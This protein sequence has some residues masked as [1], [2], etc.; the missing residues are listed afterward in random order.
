LRGSG[1]RVLLLRKTPQ[2][3][4]CVAVTKGEGEREKVREM[5]QI[6]LLYPPIKDKHVSLEQ[7]MLKEQ[8]QQT[9]QSNFLVIFSIFTSPTDLLN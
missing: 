3:K 9:F 6:S 8:L 1:K 7:E 5:A 2:R 4:P